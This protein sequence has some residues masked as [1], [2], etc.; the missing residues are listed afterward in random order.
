M[1]RSGFAAI[2]TDALSGAL[3]L[4]IGSTALLGGAAR[5]AAVLAHRTEGEIEQATALG[6]F[7]GIGLGV[8]ALVMDSLA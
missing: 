6:L 3:A 5:Y 4:L 1:I 7:F 2:F 8:F